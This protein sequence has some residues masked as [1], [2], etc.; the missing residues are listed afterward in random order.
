MKR[1]GRSIIRRAERHEI[2]EFYNLRVAHYVCELDG[3]T[4]AMGTTTRAGDRLWG[5][6][7]V[8]EGLTARE[9]KAVLYAIQRGL[10]RMGEPVYVTSN[11]GVHD[12]ATKLL[13]TIGFMPT[14]EIRNGKQIWVWMHRDVAD[15]IVDQREAVDA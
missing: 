2:E 10:R 12:R 11:E 8:A 5:F 9:A 4:L 15:E 1:E 6:F 7:D 13:R 3:K 14:D